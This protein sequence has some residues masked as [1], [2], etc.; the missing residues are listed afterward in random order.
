M[1]AEREPHDAVQDGRLEYR[2]RRG[3]QVASQYDADRQHFRGDRPALQR[4]QHHPQHQRTEE[5]GESEKERGHPGTE[6]RCGI[7]V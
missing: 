5:Q 7:L 6:V 4:A 2:D 3:G 1:H